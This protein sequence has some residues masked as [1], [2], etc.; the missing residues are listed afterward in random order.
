[1]NVDDEWEN[2]LEGGDDIVSEDSNED[3]SYS[4]TD[5]CEELYI[6]EI[7]TSRTLLVKSHDLINVIG[8]TR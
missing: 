5:K 1:M 7:S 8:K 3:I 2:F 6:G 4:P